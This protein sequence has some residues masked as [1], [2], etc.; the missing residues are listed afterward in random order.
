MRAGNW[1]QAHD[2]VQRAIDVAQ[3]TGDRQRIAW[4]NVMKAH[5]FAWQGTGEAEHVVQPLAQ[6]EAIFRDV[7]HHYGMLWVIVVGAGG[8]AANEDF[9]QAVIE[10]DRAVSW[11]RE[12]TGFHH[13][14]IAAI[15]LS[16]EFSLELGRFDE[17]NARAKE[18]LER[19][20]RGRNMLETGRAHAVLAETAWRCHQDLD[21]AEAEY[22]TAIDE[23]T[24]SSG[25]NIVR[26]HLS[27]ARVAQWRG[28]VKIAF[29]R[30]R[31]A[32]EIAT[33][34]RRMH[35]IARASKLLEEL[36]PKVHSAS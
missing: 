19:Q 13:E 32:Y 34:H 25:S 7:D 10:C 4:A 33:S 11:C 14:E 22:A 9:E 12:S 6:A 18:L 20:G 5:H 3:Q 30:A 28:D 35:Y 15:G 26:A 2:L 24:K 21:R 1:R 36:G 16:A 29:D 8:A 23:F 31:S 27:G 17:A